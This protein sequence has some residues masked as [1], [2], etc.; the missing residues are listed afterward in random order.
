MNPSQPSMLLNNPLLSH[1]HII[2]ISISYCLY[3]VKYL[4]KLFLSLIFY[5][6]HPKSKVPSAFTGILQRPPYSLS[7]FTLDTALPSQP[8]FHIIA[9]MIF[10][11]GKSDHVTYL[12]PSVVF[13]CSQ[14]GQNYLTQPITLSRVWGNI[15]FYSFFLIPLPLLSLLQPLFGLFYVPCFLLPRGL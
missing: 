5:H 11:K 7:P 2:G 1:S 8:I 12:K 13:H 10:S 9:R 6:N 14:Y 4:S 3:F 15:N